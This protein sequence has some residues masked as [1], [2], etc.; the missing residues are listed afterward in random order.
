VNEGGV[1]L[2]LGNTIR[3]KPQ[4]HTLY[5]QQHTPDYT[6]MI[7][8]IEFIKS[9]KQTKTII[10]EIR[11]LTSELRNSQKRSKDRELI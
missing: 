1:C 4:E 10:W 7:K 3:L 6:K 11:L 9:N 5:L 2:K 8:N